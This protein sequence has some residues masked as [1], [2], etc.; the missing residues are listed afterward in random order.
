MAPRITLP[1][2]LNSRGAR[3]PISVA[4]EQAVIAGWTGRDTAKME[5]HIQELEKLGVTRPAATPLFYRVAA[6]RL[7]L[8]DAIEASGEQ[9]SGEVEF[10]LV[11][12]ANALYVGV[13]SDHTDREV[14][15]YGVTVSKQMCDK[16]ISSD[17]WPYAEIADHWD[18]LVIRSW[19]ISSGAR[20]LYQEGSVAAMR[21]P[22]DLIE[23][24]T[25]GQALAPGTVMFGGTLPAIGGVAPAVRFEFELVDPVLD[26]RISHGYDIIEL[27]I[28]G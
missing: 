12:D 11:Q 9:S 23:R 17:V 15:T 26:R 20:R 6:A 3:E 8:A 10:V 16:P 24:Y 27:P 19:A 5:E 21:A 22:D 7:T 13:G 28:A 2:T 14:E 1:L 25:D 4:V 18:E